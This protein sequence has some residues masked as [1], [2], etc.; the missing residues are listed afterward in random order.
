MN[1]Q[2]RKDSL[3]ELPMPMGL[4]G[5]CFPNDLCQIEYKPAEPVYLLVMPQS[6]YPGPSEEGK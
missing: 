5:H 4:F 6:I 1:Q 2:V 3:E